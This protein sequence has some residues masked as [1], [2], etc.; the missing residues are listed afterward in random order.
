MGGL[1]KVAKIAK[2]ETGGYSLYEPSDMALGVLV[3]FLFS[4]VRGSAS[5]DMF[6][7]WLSGE[8]YQEYTAIHGN[9]YGLE[10]LD[11]RI[12]VCYIQDL[13]E[14]RYKHFN[15]TKDKMLKI[16][17]NWVKAIRSKPEPNTILI[18]EENE[19]VKF[20]TQD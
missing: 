4:S 6:T 14:E 7:D 12:Y 8:D 10:L 5:L 13:E 3:L 15:T 19:E 16:L 20:I 17:V 18:T 9:I 1:V 2:N 11:G